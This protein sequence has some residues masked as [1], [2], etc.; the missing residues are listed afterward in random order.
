[1]GG[2]DSAADGPKHDG[3]ERA[4]RASGYDAFGFL[5]GALGSF[6]AL[7]VVGTLAKAAWDRS[8][9]TG[10]DGGSVPPSSSSGNVDTPPRRDD[11]KARRAR[12]DGPP[13]EMR[14]AIEMSSRL[15]YGR[16]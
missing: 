9:A 16:L 2:D 14:G 5:F 8:G 11:T 6:G 3:A 13:F 15:G 1:M 10:S 4:K 12:G 7:V